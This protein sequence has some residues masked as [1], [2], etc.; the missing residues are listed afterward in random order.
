MLARITLVALAFAVTLSGV[1]ARDLLARCYLD[2]RWHSESR[3][4]WHAETV[5]KLSD[6]QRTVRSAA[7]IAQLRTILRLDRFQPRQRL[8]DDFCFVADIR[9]SDGSTESYY[10]GRLYVMSAD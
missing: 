1:D 10:A 6:V 8:Q 3:A 7:E 5:R 4:A 9:H 2:S